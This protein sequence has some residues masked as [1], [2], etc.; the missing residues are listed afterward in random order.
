MI[1]RP[2]KMHSSL[3]KC[4]LPRAVNGDVLEEAPYVHCLPLPVKAE[5][6]GR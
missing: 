3:S 6:G 5:V 1:C 4:A 2:G